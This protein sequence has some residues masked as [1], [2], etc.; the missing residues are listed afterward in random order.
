[1][2]AISG[3]G[4]LGS[5]RAANFSTAMRCEMNV[6]VSAKTSPPVG[7]VG[8]IMA[9]DEVAHRLVGYRGDRLPVGLR[10]A[11]D[12]LGSKGRWQ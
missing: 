8:M 10:L 5:L 4:V 2:N 1:M 9:V 3:T 7:M 6:A 12:P 11:Q